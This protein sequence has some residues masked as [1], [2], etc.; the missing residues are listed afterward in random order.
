M[1]RCPGPVLSALLLF[2]PAFCVCQV[3]DISICSCSSTEVYVH[4]CAG[5][6]VQ[7]RDLQ[8]GACSTVIRIRVGTSVPTVA[9]PSGTRAS[10]IEHCCAVVVRADPQAFFLHATLVEDMWA[11]GLTAW[12][13]RSHIT[14]LAA[15][16]V[17]RRINF[18]AIASAGPCCVPS[19]FIVSHVSWKQC[20]AQ[21]V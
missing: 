5:N 21:G 15:A 12:P 18:A 1:F 7:Q 10:Q 2:A 3:L 20:G 17:Y 14:L 6:G 16:S 19:C 8:L 11:L 9:G 4:S 13:Y